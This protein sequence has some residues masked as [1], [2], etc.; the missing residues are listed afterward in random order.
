MC[1]RDRLATC[2]FEP[3]RDA[4]RGIDLIMPMVKLYTASAFVREIA[5]ACHAENQDFDNAVKLQ[6]EAVDMVR[7]KRSTD[8][9]TD[10]QKTGL[11]NR[12]ELYRNQVAYRMDKLSEIPIR[13]I[14]KRLK[15]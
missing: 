13:S 8:Q 6:Q 4:D 15:K 1:I 7:E 5:A 3:L 9:Y 2:P 12:L 11:Q 10:A 14:G